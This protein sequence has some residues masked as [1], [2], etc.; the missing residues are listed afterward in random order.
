M[1]NGYELALL[2]DRST[3]GATKELVENWLFENPDDRLVPHLFSRLVEMEED[4]ALQKWVKR[5]FRVKKRRTSWSVLPVLE[6]LPHNEE[7]FDLSR[8]ILIQAHFP[9][10]DDYVFKLLK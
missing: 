1:M 3:D 7:F 6:H 5:W 10:T 2:C 8:E 9:W 4:E